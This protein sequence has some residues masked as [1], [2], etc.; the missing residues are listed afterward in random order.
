ML[1]RPSEVVLRHLETLHQTPTR[2]WLQES[3]D[4]TNLDLATAKGEELGWAQGAAQTL[5]KLIGMIDNSEEFR[6]NAQRQDIPGD[7]I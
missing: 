5:R 4:Q 7:A 1:R 2:G 3:L 6:K